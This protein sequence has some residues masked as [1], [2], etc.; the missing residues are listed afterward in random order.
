MWSGSLR[1]KVSDVRFVSHGISPSGMFLRIPMKV[2]GQSGNVL[3]R[4][5]VYDHRPQGA[6][7]TVKIAAPQ[8]AR[9]RDS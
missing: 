7:Q 2:T 9:S 1:S 6:F 5:D 8:R 3:T 4:I